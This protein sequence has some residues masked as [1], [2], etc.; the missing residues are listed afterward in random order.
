MSDSVLA[1]ELPEFMQGDKEITWLLD[2]LIPEQSLSI[3]A[4]KPK[5]GKSI[6]SLNLALALRL[7]KLFLGRVAKPTRTLILQL[8]DPPVLIRNRLIKMHPDIELLDG[9][10]IRSGLPMTKEDWVNVEEFIKDNSIGLVII[11]PLI[12]A[13]GAN[14]QDATAMAKILKDTREV[15]FTTGCSI[16]L[17]HHHRKSGGEYGDAIRGSSAILGA[18]DVALELFREN[19]DSLTATLKTTSRMASVED[20]IIT[21]DVETLTWRSQGRASDYKKTKKENQI[22]QA[23]QNGEMSISELEDELGLTAPNFR[24]DLNRLVE[25]GLV[26]PRKEPTGKRPKLFYSL[27]EYTTIDDI[28]DSFS[29]IAEK[30]INASSDNVLSINDDFLH[31]KVEKNVEYANP[32]KNTWQCSSCKKI[33]GTQEEPLFK[34]SQGDICKVCWNEFSKLETKESC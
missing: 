4:A 28:Q 26:N 30:E 15:I 8:E 18:C 5:V 17:V 9:I 27:A 7:N 22:L 16:L 20:E 11:D 12:F 2:G 14:E 3:L 32:Q 23:L 10:F 34:S 33:A 6:L 29:T 21:L 25:A 1:I 24:K 31:P 13:I 19:E